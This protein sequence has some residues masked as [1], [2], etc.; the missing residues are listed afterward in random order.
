MQDFI[1]FHRFLPKLVRNNNFLCLLFIE[2]FRVRQCYL[3]RNGRAFLV[4]K[5]TWSWPHR[6]E[7]RMEFETSFHLV[8]RNIW[9]RLG[10]IKTATKMDTVFVNISLCNFRGMPL[11]SMRGVANSWGG[12]LQWWIHHRFNRL[13]DQLED[14]SDCRRNTKW[15][16]LYLPNCFFTWKMEAIVGE[17]AGTARCNGLRKRI[18]WAIATGSNSRTDSDYYY[19][20]KRWFTFEYVIHGKKDWSA[21]TKS[22]LV[23]SIMIK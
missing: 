9:H 15:F 2:S 14:N 10:F 16:F 1:H 19:G 13:Q 12:I 8:H 5:Q 6:Y 4:L 17:I 23:C 22:F 7:F 21:A 3:H 18:I 11:R 20:N